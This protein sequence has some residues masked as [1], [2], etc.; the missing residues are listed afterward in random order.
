MLVKEQMARVI[1]EEERSSPRWGASFF[2][3]TTQDVARAVVAAMNSQRPCVVYALKNHHGGSQLQRLQYQVKYTN[4]IWLIL[5]NFWSL[6]LNAFFALFFLQ[7]FGPSISDLK[8]Q[9]FPL[10]RQTSKIHVFVLVTCHYQCFQFSAFYFQS[11]K[12]HT[13]SLEL[14]SSQTLIHPL[15]FEFTGP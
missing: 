10:S 12:T 5:L 3:Q 7:R 9:L 6:F 4:L 2:T 8:I 13:N 14:N 11:T 15:K 1:K